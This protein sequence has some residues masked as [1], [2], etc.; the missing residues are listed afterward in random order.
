M[1]RRASVAALLHPNNVVLVGAS[2]R[3]GHWSPR[4]WDNLRRFAFK[5]N[6]YAVNPG[7]TEIWGTRCYPD[8]A[9]LPEPPDHLAL[10]VPAD[11]TLEV[12]E[13]AGALGARGATL[14]AAGFGEGG[15]EQGRKRAE[16]LR[17]ILVRT[18]IAA[19]GPNCMGLACGRSGLVTIADETLQP[20][21]HGPIAVLTQSGALAASFN[22][23]MNDR[24]LGVSHLVSCGNQ[25]GLT[26]ADYID[27]LADDPEVRAIL[28]YIEMI[29]DAP[30]FLAAAAKAREAGKRVVV[31]KIGGSETARAA[32]LAHT[33]A[34]VGSLDAFDV[35]ARG[36]G[37]VRVGSLEEMIEAAELLAY[38]RLSPTRSFAFM[39]NSGALKSLMTEAAERHGVPLAPLQGSAVAALRSAL[40]PD[41][42]P[43][44]PL[45]TK[46]TILTNTYMACVD[47]LGRADGVDLVVA[48]EE[49]PREAGIA[50]KVANLEAL[51][52]SAAEIL[53]GK[54]AL[55]VL[56]PLAF[57]DTDY[58]RQLRRRLPHLPLLRG[59]DTTFSM[60]AALAA[61][62][63][64]MS[65]GTATLPFAS[66][67]AATHAIA[68]APRG[69][70]EIES[71]RLVARYGIAL[72]REEV[73][74]D[75]RSAVD[76]ARNLGYPVVMKAVSAEVAHK[77]DAGLVILGIADE[78]AAAR[79][80][81]KIAERCA[82]IGAPLEG[83]LVAEQVKDGVEMV[84]GLHRDPE[85]GLVL[86]VGLGGVWLEVIR[87]FALAP[88]AITK[89][90]ALDAIGRTKACKLLVGFRGSPVCDIDALADAMVALGRMA[91]D[92]ADTLE[93][94]D[95]N[96]LL[97]RAKGRAAV[98]LDALVVMR[99]PA[100]V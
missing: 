35:V 26:F 67:N 21:V 34:L 70:S 40:G 37:V 32:A 90:G 88:V 77:S 92:M 84:L 25:V 83:I 27:H 63:K 14:F 22:R 8:L 60:L 57:S 19:A 64:A 55:A 81:D 89:A 51:E 96:P 15:D 5:G 20:L 59:V 2:D 12:L 38:A 68:S 7:R 82:A 41:A 54:P 80:A 39:T 46:K 66:V 44:N 4:V 75:A 48:L 11:V 93:S 98:A 1:T 43:S 94:V 99:G 3:S 36:A 52:A 50:R 73:A 17:A 71:K 28:C 87:D 13:E 18:G 24:G 85:M 79:A 65:N 78:A 42:E 72:P 69:L 10:F 33:G 61:T 31:V 30:R 23:A 86:M 53:V 49:L 100:S 9:S 29:P 56:S 76:V 62:D 97:V 6:V 95:V 16:R 47:A 91:A 58:M 74:G 45:D